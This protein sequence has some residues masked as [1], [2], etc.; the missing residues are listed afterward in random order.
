MKNTHI[1]SLF[2]LIFLFVSSF[3]NAQDLTSLL[4]D[5]EQNED[6]KT[7]ASILKQIA[8]EYEKIQA[9]EKANE[10][11]E[12]LVVIQKKLNDKEGQVE[13]YSHLGTNHFINE[14]YESAV[15]NYKEIIKVSDFK[16][17]IPARNKIIEVF[18]EEENYSEAL[19]YNNELTQYYDKNGM[20]QEKAAALNTMGFLSKKLGNKE[21]AEARFNEALSINND[22]YEQEK[23]KPLSAQQSSILINRGVANTHLENYGGAIDSY[24]EALKIADSQNDSLAVA[25]LNNYMA[26][27]Y[28]VNGNTGQAT[29]KV[30]S[31]IELGE[32]LNNKEVL[33]DSYKILSEINNADG[34]FQA[35][36]NA[37]KRHL[38]LKDEL[39][40]EAEDTR[41][42]L[43]QKQ[44]DAERNENILKQAI[45]KQK[46]QELA[47]NQA[48][49]EAE[50][51][52]Q[53][54]ALQERQL[55]LLNRDKELQ[56]SRLA[57]QELEQQRVQQALALANQNL[58][59]ERQEKEL[60]D[61]QQQ[62]EIEQKEQDLQ[63]AKQ[64]QE[65]ERIEAEKKLQEQE[66][67]ERQ[68]TERYYLYALIAGVIFVGFIL[69][70]IIQRNKAYKKLTE[71]KKEIDSKND[72]L[73]ASE[74]ELR[75]NME[76]LKTTQDALAQQNIE[77]GAK[78]R[79]VTESIQAAQMIQTAILPTVA[80]R[81][82]MFPNNFTIFRPKDIVS[83]D[84]FWIF[85]DDT[86]K[87]AA[88]VDCTGHGVPGAFMSL[89]GADLLTEIVEVRGERSPAMVLQELNRNVRKKLSQEEGL[90]DEGMDLVFC[91]FEKAEE[92]QVKMTFAGAKGK[93]Y[94]VNNGEVSEIK[95]DRKAIGGKHNKDIIEFTNQEIILEPDTMLYLVTDGFIDQANVKR[96]RFSS[97]KFKKI[98]S[99]VSGLTLENQKIELE[100]ELEEHQGE[101]PQRDDI[102]VLGLKV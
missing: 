49:L 84:F 89:V 19:A 65:L 46:E 77:L 93:M 41:R 62:R 45:A 98:L 57:N 75:Q 72:E 32:L 5:L 82:K 78:N 12:K 35:S 30:E 31:A 21:E 70:S 81:N 1:K 86:M 16:T 28:L 88:V 76:E 94:M 11:F 83:G 101:E 18:T 71:Q 22:L 14:D 79:M 27:T 92:S 48:K 59:R 33:A 67:A 85:E 3:V 2:I 6:E 4:T 74:E 63:S 60:A 8:L 39:E 10:Y 37:F 90:S 13:S 25:D 96:K 52:E 43:I 55:E 54:L 50:K 38:A 58:E 69:F 66:I 20:S 17:S 51:S 47:L 68:K 24:N 97:V 42:A 9:Y 95:G 99:N 87:M 26:A 100:R 102:T 64:Q 44:I 40:A 7:E 36:Q 80:Q 34:D 53:E 91:K 23:S 56:E 15:S 29:S 61:L 73:V